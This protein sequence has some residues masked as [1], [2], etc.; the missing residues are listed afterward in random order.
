MAPDVF[1]G[2]NNNVK[3]MPTPNKHKIHDPYAG[4][5][6]DQV[7]KYRT[8]LLATPEGHTDMA[9]EACLKAPSISN[10]FDNDCSAIS[11][12]SPLKVPI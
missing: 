10:I 11:A 12:V 4:L 3:R 2:E 8:A 5:P 7:F 9:F 1:I 6:S